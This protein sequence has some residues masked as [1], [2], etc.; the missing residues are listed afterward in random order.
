M[1]AVRVLAEEIVL[2][3]LIYTVVVYGAWRV[4]ARPAGPERTLQHV[5][6]RALDRWT[7]RYAD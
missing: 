4:G 7:H 5:A 3:A 6:V 1:T 2:G